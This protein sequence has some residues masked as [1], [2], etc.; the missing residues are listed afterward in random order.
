M[1][2]FAS[3]DDG[4]EGPERLHPHDG[5]RVA[6]GVRLHGQRHPRLVGALDVVPDPEDK[7]TLY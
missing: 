4:N 1:L 2:L 7:G 3:P 6:L 5:Q